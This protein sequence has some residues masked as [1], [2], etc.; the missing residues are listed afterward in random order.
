MALNINVANSCTILAVRGSRYD[1]AS[2]SADLTI[3][4]L[5]DETAF[6]TTMAYDTTTGRGSINIPVSSLTASNGAFKVCLSENS[7]EY[8][9]KPV[10]IK[11]DIDCCLTKLTNEL[12]DCD[13]DCPRCAKS[14][15]KA[16]KIF[17]LLQSAASA[18]ELAGSSNTI[19]ASAYYNEL[20]AK[21]NKARELCDNSCGCDC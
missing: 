3:T 1:P 6:T 18:V 19:T 21:Y 15:A 5:A 11:C 16:Q 7:I 20:L 10:L 13:C 14:L 4:N 8:V 12:I 17:L 2:T 9:C